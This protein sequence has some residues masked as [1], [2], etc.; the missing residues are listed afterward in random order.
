MTDDKIAVSCSSCGSGRVAHLH[1]SP[2]TGHRVGRCA[3]CGLVFALSLPAPGELDELYAS[4]ED[5]G[6]YLGAQQAAGLHERHLE[7]LRRL[8][9][10]VPPSGTPRLFDVGAGAGDFLALAR[11]QGFAVSGSEI[12]AP[13]AEAAASRHGIALHRGDL[14]ELDLAEKFD[15]VTLWCVLAH[16]V[17]PDELLRRCLLL[18][19][20]GGVLYLHTP[21]WCLLD[22]VGLVGSR[23]SGGRLPHV[24]DRRVNSAHLR[25]YRRGAMVAALRAAGF[26]VVQVDPKVGYSLQTRSYLAGMGLPASLHGPVAGPF[27]VLIKRGWFVRNILDV[28][29]RR[30]AEDQRRGPATTS[31]RVIPAAAS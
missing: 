18:L 26:G 19:R 11:R 4:P 29:A 3:D 17:D 21:R 14:A 23:A 8:T 6:R 9:D 16:V 2:R 5:Y 10:L 12:S 1:T 13:A 27:D 28:Y 31:A 20:P 7:V 22:S 15:A 24:I 25:L 30:P